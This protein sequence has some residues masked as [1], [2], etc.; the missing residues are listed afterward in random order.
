VAFEIEDF[1]SVRLTNVNP[2]MEKHG[3]EAVPAVDINFVMDKPN[4]VLS[5]FDGTLL[6]ALYKPATEAAEDQEELDGIDPISSFPCLRFPKMARIKWDWRGAGYTLAIDYGL[7]EGRNLE[8]EGCEVGKV[9]LDCKE[10]GTVE[11]KFQVQ[12][13]KGLTEHILGKLA[14][15]IGQEVSI[16]LAAPK[17]LEET[18]AKFDPLF[19]DYT[20]D[21]PL[22]AEDVFIN[23]EASVH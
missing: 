17:T 15:M 20:P 23:T 6:T 1:E 7:G 8:L 19:P 18:G 21:K 16:M 22:T 4:S 10:G 12:C 14:L 9:V 11:I 13:D 5:Y 3:P 2:R